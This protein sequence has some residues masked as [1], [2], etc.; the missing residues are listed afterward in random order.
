VVE[1]QVPGGTPQSFI[2][3]G[4]EA[5]M[6]GSQIME[7]PC[8]RFPFAASFIFISSLI[9]D[10]LAEFLELWP[11]PSKGQAATSLLI[12][13]HRR[14][15][16]GKAQ[17][18]HYVAAGFILGPSTEQD[19]AFPDFAHRASTGVFSLWIMNASMFFYPSLHLDSDR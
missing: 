4:K 18:P 7:I 15:R 11:Q 3:W 12:P 17:G 6:I 13:F 16:F 2:D 19:T 10:Q 9:C 1:R 8:A 5:P 14:H